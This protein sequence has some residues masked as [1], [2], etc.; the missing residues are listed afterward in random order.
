MFG[1]SRRPCPG[2][3]RPFTGVDAGCGVDE[4]PLD[5]C[6]DEMLLEVV[7]VVTFV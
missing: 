6:V 3:G 1:S 2:R 4:M 7:F 5:R